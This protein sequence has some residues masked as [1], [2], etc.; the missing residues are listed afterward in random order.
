M[1]N[2]T[3][4]TDDVFSNDSLCSLFILLFIYHLK[5]SVYHS[6]FSALTLLVGWQLG[7]P[8]CKN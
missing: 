7:H 5:L 2:I 4:A 6:A 1:L 3:D 8:A